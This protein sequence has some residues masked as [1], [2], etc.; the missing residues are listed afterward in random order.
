MTTSFDQFSLIPDL[1]AAVADM[2]Y[3]RPTPI[4]AESI[5]VALAGRDLIG[6]ASTG[7]GKTAAFVLPILQRLAAAGH[8]RCRALVL[9]PTRELALQ[10]DEQVLALGYHVGL[11]AVTVVGGMDMRPQ[12]RALRAGAEIVVATPG[13]LLDH[14]RFGYVNLSGL[15]VL[16]IDEAD[17]MLDMGFLPDIRRILA[18]LPVERQT[19]MFSATMAPQILDLASAILRD[20]VKIVVGSQKPAVGIVQSVYPVAEGRKPALLTTLLRHEA[21]RSVLVF[22]KRKVDASRLTRAVVRAGIRATS[23]HADRSQEER[24]AALESFRKGETPVLIATDVASRGIDVE[25]ISH[26]IN[27][28][29]P[30]SGDAYIH[31]SGRT[32]RAGAVGEVITFVAPEEESE[33]LTIEEAIGCTLPRVFLPS[34]DHGAHEHVPPGVSEGRGNRSRSHGRSRGEGAA[35]GRRETDPEPTKADP[36]P[37]GPRRRRRRR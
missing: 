25:G 21:M 23:I 9:A 2:G 6:C 19:M 26:V 18:A 16:V 13:R 24:I 37:S 27:F 29:V 5:P 32:A 31:R 10:I 7:T 22:V 28:N 33:L 4:Q 3:S 34:F 15:Q 12:E 14:M 11:T 20:P 35:H 8:G 17:R 36:V 1:K 30:F